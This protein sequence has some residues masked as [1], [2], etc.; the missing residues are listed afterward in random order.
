M[1]WY[2]PPED[3]LEVAIA[4]VKEAERKFKAEMAKQNAAKKR[5]KAQQ[6][7][8]NKKG[9]RGPVDGSDPRDKS[10]FE[11][12][13]YAQDKREDE[14]INRGDESEN[15]EDSDDLAEENF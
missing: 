11:N 3:W 8:F 10:P 14:G 6:A 4:D 15:S 12:T 13:K 2:E 9:G 7:A 5:K 1:P